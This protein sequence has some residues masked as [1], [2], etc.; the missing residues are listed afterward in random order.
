MIDNEIKETILN[1]HQ[2]GV[3]IRQINRILNVSR[4]T[5]RQV[6]RGKW[7]EAPMRTSRYEEM[8]PIIQELFNTC[9]GNAVRVQEILS[10]QYGHLIPYSSLTRLVRELELRQGKK[11]HRAGQYEFAP[12]QEMQH[13]TSPHQVMLNGKKVK[14]QCASLVMA[15][16][17]KLFIQYYP[18]FTRFEA[19]VFLSEAFKFMQGTCPRCVIDNTSVIVVH[20]SGANADMAPEMECFGKIFGLTFMAHE[21]GDKDRS[22]RVERNFSYIE[23]NFLAGRTFTD[24]H[25]LNEQARAWCIKVANPKPKRSLGMS[26]D[27]AYV[28]EKPYLNSLPPY[29]PPVYQSLDRVVDVAGY[30]RVDTNRYSVPERLVGK[31]VEVHKLWDRVRIFFKRQKVADHPRLIDKRET[32]ITAKGHHPPFN[33][34]KAHRGPCKEEQILRGHDESLDHYV[35]ELKKRS[36]GRGIIKMRRLLALKQTYP[37][38][39]FKKAIEE[40]LHYG[41]Y[42]L[43][44]LEQMILSYVAGEFFNLNEDEMD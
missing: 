26:P 29:I 5:V 36:S 39:P 37:R 24:W 12:G 2:R 16:S 6:L 4:N 23:G 44:R 19:K 35:A 32:R 25:D 3:K 22:A 8:T 10:D 15:Y 28:L 31:K 14:A 33:R 30:V 18:T 34:Y 20:G 13:D 7:Q 40:A 42:D 27:A 9:K 21:I 38:Q 17:R 41:L 43:S 11:K 1:L